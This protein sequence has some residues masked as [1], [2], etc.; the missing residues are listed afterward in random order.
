MPYLTKTQNITLYPSGG[1]SSL[2][3]LDIK[4]KLLRF[5]YV[6]NLTGNKRKVIFFKISRQS[7]VTEI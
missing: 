1:V 7:G 3:N 6:K 5:S 2:N 4:L